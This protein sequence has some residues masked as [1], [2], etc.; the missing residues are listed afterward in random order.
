MSVMYDKPITIQKQNEE[1]ERWEDLLHLHARVNRTGGG[2][3][4]NAGADQYH[5]SLTFD[6]RYASALEEMRYSP[7]LYRIVYRGRKFKLADYDDYLE[8]H[9]TVKMVGEMYE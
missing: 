9:R 3:A 7:Q 2:Q 6:V 8:Q 5:P 1:T 4:M